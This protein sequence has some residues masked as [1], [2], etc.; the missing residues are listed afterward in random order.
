MAN[1][2]G[3]VIYTVYFSAKTG[4]HLVYLNILYVMVYRTYSVELQEIMSEFQ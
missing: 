3:P 1:N 2:Y 4:K